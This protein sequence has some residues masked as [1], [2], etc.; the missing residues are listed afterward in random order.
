MPF[1]TELQPG[2]ALRIGDNTTITVEAKSGKRTRVRVD[3]PLPVKRVGGEAKP[4][5]QQPVAAASPPGAR[6]RA[7]APEGAGPR[8]QLAMPSFG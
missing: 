8:P 4:S 6:A 7:V 3:S 1:I 2:E 5:M